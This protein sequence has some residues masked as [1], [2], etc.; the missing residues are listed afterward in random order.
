MR[1]DGGASGRRGQGEE[2]RGNGAGK[3]S[4]RGRTG[5]SFHGSY[6]T[7]ALVPH[8][9]GS[10]IGRDSF[11]ASLEERSFRKASAALSGLKQARAAS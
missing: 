3:L 9:V 7:H 11:C 6:L 5:C 8:G 1:S 10:K 2:Q 4:M